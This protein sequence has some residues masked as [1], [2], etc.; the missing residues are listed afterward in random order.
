MSFDSIQVGRSLHEEQSILNG[1]YGALITAVIINI[2]WVYFSMFFDR[3]FPWIGIIQGILIGKSV[4][5][6]GFGLDWYLPF[7]AA[8]FAIT[9]SFT[10]SFLSALNLTGREFNTGAMALINE[11]SLHT[12]RTFTI[13]EFAIVGW[14]YAIFAAALA[15]YYAK[16]QLSRDQAIAFRKYRESIQ[17]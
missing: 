4:R 12:I 7:L 5:K 6:Y 17:S 2:I 9:A 14:V 3:F 13:N 11:I 8:I 1:F 16:R 10:G 15:A